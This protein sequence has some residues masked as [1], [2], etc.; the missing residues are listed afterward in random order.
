VGILAAIAII[1]L[2]ILLLPIKFCV[3]ADNTDGLIV[4]SAVSYGQGLVSYTYGS[5]N[6]DNKAVVKLLGLPVYNFSSRPCPDDP[7]KTD[8]IGGFVQKIRARKRLLY[9]LPGIIRDTISAIIG[10]KVRIALKLGFEDPA[11]TGMA[12]GLAACIFSYCSGVLRYTPDF[13]GD[14]FEVDLYIKGVII[15][16][17]LILIGVKYGIVYI[18][19][20]ILTRNNVKGG[21]RYGF[22]G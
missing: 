17:A 16:L 11:Y 19:E 13:S 3:T 7:G 12:A 9:L 8:T 21:K 15:P 20:Q 1:L 14:S 6:T 4:E 18:R 10:K 22:K 5:C 2:I